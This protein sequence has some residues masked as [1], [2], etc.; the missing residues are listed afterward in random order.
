ML[1]RAIGY[2]LVIVGVLLII[3]S[4]IKSYP[5]SVQPN[6][7][8]FGSIYFSYWIG[9][10]AGNA[11]LFLVASSSRRSIERFSCAVTFF[12]LAF[13]LRFFYSFVSGP[14]S[15]YFR[16]LI[17]YFLS[18]GSLLAQQQ[19][20]YQ[21]P[22]LFILGAM[23]SEVLGLDGH[24][25]SVVL[26]LVWS[27][28][29]AGLLFFYQKPKDSVADFL[30]IA[31]YVIVPYAWLN[32][33]FAAQTLALLL[34][35]A[36]VDVLTKGDRTNLAL[37][38]ILYISLVLAHPFFALFLV[39]ATIPL[40]LRDRRQVT[41]LFTFAL[42]FVFYFVFETTL[43]VANVGQTL[44]SILLFH[45]YSIAAGYI[46]TTPFSPVDAAAQI[47]SR[48]LVLS[49]GGLLGILLLWVIHERKVRAIDLGIIFSGAVDLVAGAVL[50]YIGPRAFQ[51]IMMPVANVLRESALRKRVWQAI[52]VFMLLVLIL[53]PVALIHLQYADTNYMS[54]N[55]QRAAELILLP[56]YGTNSGE[57][58]TT[59]TRTIV[60]QY[61]GAKTPN[62][63][64]F[65][66]ERYGTAI[67][68]DSSQ[69]HF[70]LDSPELGIALVTYGGYSPADLGR[71][72]AVESA[73]S[74]IY[75]DGRVTVYW[76]E[77]Q[78]N[79]TV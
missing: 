21:W 60:D 43:L 33:Q 59:V 42:I 57:N 41:L 73:M 39:A 18:T 79:G 68:T 61:L 28:S 47:V 66:P 75:S 55:E 51:V 23:T 13:S 5:V 56:S 19:T 16:G 63:P 74:T 44:S 40:I 78:Q 62:A 52:Q 14:D 70:I 27:V 26:F 7:Y 2:V 49:L 37:G 4:W 22:N 65:M 76:N 64:H 24:A 15:D 46:L 30:F 72:H 53:F 69:I 8:L 1:R 35:V 32:W 67:V 17:E 54:L 31:S 58:L 71:L 20:Y 9:L 10:S 36:C 77:Y 34:F 3:L 6:G 29:F 12:V 48:A 25:I 50:P 45:Q 11:G 38:L